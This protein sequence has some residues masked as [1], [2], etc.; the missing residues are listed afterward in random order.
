VQGAEAIEIDGTEI[1]SPFTIDAIGSP[2]GLLSTLDRPG[3]IKAQ[4]EQSVAAT[5]II[6]QRQRIEV[7]ASERDLTPQVAQ[8]VE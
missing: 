1:G 5:I 2:D 4:L 7:P 3:G 8:P 6:E